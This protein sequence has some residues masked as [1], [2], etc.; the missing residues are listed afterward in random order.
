MTYKRFRWFFWLPFV[1]LLMSGVFIVPTFRAN[2]FV[3]LVECG[4]LAAAFVGYF[5]WLTVCR[6]DLSHIIL[7][8]VSRLDVSKKKS[9]NAFPL[10]V[11]VTDGEGS[12]LL[13]NKLFSDA[14]LNGSSFENGSIERLIPGILCEAF[15]E[16]GMEISRAGRYFTVYHD[17]T[18]HKEK[19]MRIFYFAENTELKKTAIE[20]S[21]SRPYVLLL[22][23]DGI[24]EIQKNYSSNDFAE[25]RMRL[26]RLVGT[27]ASG[28]NAVY[29]KMSMEMYVIIAESRNIDSMKAAKFRILDDVRNFAFHDRHVGVTLSVGVGCGNT[30][31]ECENSARQALDMAQSRGGDQVALRSQNGDYEFFGGIAKGIEKTNKVRTRIVAGSVAELIRAS[32]NVMIMGH[33]F[34]DLDAMGAATAMCSAALSMGVASYIVTDPQKS[35]AQPLLER[36]HTEGLGGCLMMPEDAIA[37]ASKETLLIV[38]D[39]HI[40]DFTEVPQ[41]LT[42]VKNIVVI[43]HHR[44]SVQFLDNAVLFFHDPAASSASEMVTELLQYISPDPV[45]GK[46]EADALLSG[47]MLDTRNFVLRA[48]VRTFEAAAYL[49]ARGADTVRVKKM[50]S[51]S[52]DSYKKRNAI[53]SASGSYRSC[54][55]A[56]ANVEGADLRVIASQAADELLNISEVDASFVLFRTAETINISARSLGK[57][58][59]QIIMEKLGGGGHQTMAAAQLAGLTMEQAEQKLREAIDSYYDSVN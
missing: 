14:I 55:I 2:R 41:L 7:H 29:D 22:S 30:F 49:K 38:V 58:N 39:T 17:E 54:S 47:I 31:A 16:D 44:K 12:V 51:S 26:D 42:K 18:V 48:G 35:L 21:L 52:L 28:F 19:R 50:F 4:V 1:F 43:D 59:V 20:Y 56:E 34:P 23:F 27:W 25:I 9:I 24:Y 15:P 46:T 3:A 40:S 32:K 53:I 5:V 45:I 33:R 11:V 10:P 57:I 36:L 8:A 13:F 37:K 6:R